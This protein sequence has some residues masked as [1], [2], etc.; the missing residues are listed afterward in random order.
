MSSENGF[1]NHGQASIG[2]Y[3]DVAGNQHNT[4]IQPRDATDILKPSA[5]MEAAWDSNARY[6]AAECFKGTRMRVIDDI[7][8]WISN[9]KNQGKMFWLTGATGLGRSSIA[10]TLAER[11]KGRGILG[12]TFFF[13]ADDIRRNDARKLFTTLAYQFCC[14]SKSHNNRVTK[15]VKNDPSIADKGPSEQYE[16]LI[17]KIVSSNFNR[18]VIILDDFHEGGSDEVLQG[19]L[20]VLQKASQSA[21]RFIITSQM[22]PIVQSFLQEHSKQIDFLDL[23]SHEAEVDRDIRHFYVS[24]FS[25]LSKY[26]HLGDWYTNQDIDRLVVISG[27]LFLFAAVV[28]KYIGEGR[29]RKHRARLDDVLNVDIRAIPGVHDRLDALYRRI[30]S[31]I[32]RNDFEVTQKLMATICQVATPLT[33]SELDALHDLESGESW[34]Y[35]QDL[36]AF[37]NVPAEDDTKSTVRLVH[38]FFRGFLFDPKRS[39]EFSINPDAHHGY[40]ATRCLDTLSNGLRRNLCNLPPTGSRWQAQMGSLIKQ[41]ASLLITGAVE[42]S[43][44]FWYYHL[45]FVRSQP[46]QETLTSLRHFGLRSILHWVEA[47]SILGR[48]GEA[49]HIMQESS[50]IIE[51]GTLTEAS[52]AQRFQVVMEATQSQLTNLLEWPLRIYDAGLPE[53]AEDNPVAI[54]EEFCEERPMPPQLAPEGQ[55]SPE[56]CVGQPLPPIMSEPGY[57]L[58]PLPEPLAPQAQ[59]QVELLLA[60][61][62]PSPLVPVI[63]ED[64]NKGIP[65]EASHASHTVVRKA[66]PP[67]AMVTPPH[68]P[69]LPPLRIVQEKGMHVASSIPSAKAA[70]STLPARNLEKPLT[71][72]ERPSVWCI[73]HVAPRS[74]KIPY[75]WP[76]AGKSQPHIDVLI[77]EIRGA[78]Y[79]DDIKAATPSRGWT[80]SKCAQL[81]GELVFFSVSDGAQAIVV[82]RS[83]HSLFHQL[84]K[85]FSAKTA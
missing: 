54:V 17:K 6:P 51:V 18:P 47:M 29:S 5:A 41:Q 27:G 4:F 40:L 69:L 49:I 42:Y 22:T 59:A 26:R 19:I 24:K 71:E 66:E 37:L 9:S 75:T 44:R 39:Q 11:C 34:G 25:H 72:Y 31:Q 48:L 85:T 76:S 30:L 58:E 36:H 52:I 80:C 77:P 56:V 35:L 46:P 14:T 45:G 7:I 82:S 79:D 20:A 63:Q 81:T 61:Q 65:P 53:S 15:L 10:H 67:P 78:S 32:P 74:F 12:G 73:D 8:D 57:E 16:A 55:Q 68:R 1:V 62:L 23:N 43:I 28:V 33:S 21:L 50:P 64:I 38:R 3:N 60:P 2:T 84:T 13:S 83:V 70:N